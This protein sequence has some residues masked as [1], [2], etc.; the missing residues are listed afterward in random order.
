VEELGLF[1]LSAFA[2]KTGV[3]WR[4]TQT[5]LAGT[6]PAG[7]L[8]DV[9]VRTLAR[10]RLTALDHLAAGRCQARIL[11]GLVHRARNTRFGREHD[12]R[13]I[14]TAADFRRLVPLRTPKQLWQHYWQPALPDLAGV[15][16]PGPV[17]TVALRPASAA[18]SADALPLSPALLNSHQAAFF[19]ALGFLA[20]S[21]PAARPL[22]GEL[23][24]VA[25]PR[26]DSLEE[27][28]AQVLPTWLGQRRVPL[29]NPEELANPLTRLA[30]RSAARPVTWVTGST[31]QLTEFFACL[32][33]LTGRDRILD[34]WPQLA[35]VVYAGGPQSPGRTRL[36]AELDSPGVLLMEAFFQPEGT[37]AL[38]DPRH[39][40]LRLLPNHG[41]YFEFVPVDEQG[42]P[43]PQRLSFEEVES[44]VAYRL[45]LTSP[46]GYWACLTDSTICFEG[47][48]P[49][50]LRRLESSPQAQPAV[51]LPFVDRELG[52]ASHPAAP[53]RALR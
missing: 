25:N 21:R 1:G 47:L 8:L 16:W 3:D 42:S 24:F 35:A 41:L 53:Q 52:A 40:L 18:G 23:L 26:V 31:E 51:V 12:F 22:T 11:R 14:R 10:R 13:R 48:S 19:T 44:G 30:E 6:R 27:I 36:A 29:A 50:L 2:E 15:T 17:N 45:A 33:H 28:A 4:A 34:V 46:A 49:P 32:K 38:E 43:R 37:I 39:G 20:V 7:Q 5:W 9:V